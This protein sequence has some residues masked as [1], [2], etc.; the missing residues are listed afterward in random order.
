MRKYLCALLSLALLFSCA[1]AEEG[2][3]R[4]GT[5]AAKLGESL[6][7]AVDEGAT[8]ALVRVAG[9]KSML[10]ARAEGV[11]PVLT[12][13]GELYYLEKADG[14]WSLMRRGEDTV[15]ETVYAFAA[16][17]SVGAL[18]E[19]GG[20]LFVLVD[21]QL[22]IVYPGQ[23]LCLRLASAKMS[24][25]AVNGE[26]AYFISATDIV[27]YELGAATADAGCL[28]RL[29]LSTGNT[30]LVMKAGVEDLQYRAGKLYFHNLSDAYLQGDSN[31]AGRLYSFDL[32]TETLTRALSDYD[33]AYFVTG[34]GILVYREGGV[35][36][37][38]ADGSA[39]AVCQAGTRAEVYFADGAVF[40]YDPDTMS[41]A[42]YP[43]SGE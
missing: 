22:H 24:E 7:F 16:G 28:Y 23:K 12:L 27:S 4:A 31:L 20:E 18:A 29:N 38:G 1:L 17:A 32:S 8:W 11:G 2:E 43:V 37:M 13:D 41:F 5:G 19:S 36:L 10:A 6:F 25:Y 33:W 9:G 40:L 42:A 15:P 14:A 21:G 3:F 39:A 26:Y 30:S 34:A 35:F